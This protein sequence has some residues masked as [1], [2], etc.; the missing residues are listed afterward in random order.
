MIKSKELNSEK[1]AFT[2]EAI[3]PNGVDGS[4]LTNPY[5]HEQGQA[6]KGT[7]A[8][9]IHNISALNKMMAAPDANSGTSDRTE[10]EIEQIIAALRSLLPSLKITAMFNLFTPE[11][12]LSGT[13]QLGRLL[14]GVLFLQENPTEATPDVKRRLLEIRS[15]NLNTDLNN[16]IDALLRICA[17]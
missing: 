15:R 1:Q 13:N 14:V 5:T 12:W 17:A 7:I 16:E 4:L 10:T 9:T 2:P 3:L 6:R 8:A 11:E